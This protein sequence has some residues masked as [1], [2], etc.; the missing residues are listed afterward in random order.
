MEVC[1]QCHAPIA[2]P[3]GKRHGAHF[4]EGAGWQSGVVW[5]AVENLAHLG[6]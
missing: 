4:T 2:L 1:G 6:I 3:F 5:T